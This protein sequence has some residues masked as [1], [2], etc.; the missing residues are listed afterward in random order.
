MRGARYTYVAYTP[1][2]H[3]RYR[4]RAGRPAVPLDSQRPQTTK[5]RDGPMSLTSFDAAPNILEQRPVASRSYSVRLSFPMSDVKTSPH[6]RLHPADN[7]PDISVSHKALCHA[8]ARVL[9]MNHSILITDTV[10]SVRLN[11]IIHSY[12]CSTHFACVLRPRPLPFVL[13][14]RSASSIVLVAI[15]TCEHYAC[16]VNMCVTV[17]CVSIYL[18]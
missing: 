6:A 11:T 13:T 17:R 10:Y 3:H 2:D 8:R 15:G 7:D 4:Y 9:F 1:T 18:I 14:F 12:M 5:S 16:M